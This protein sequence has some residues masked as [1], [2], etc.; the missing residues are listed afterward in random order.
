MQV[1]DIQ[2]VE[3]QTKKILKEAGRKNIPYLWQGKNRIT[4]DFSL[5]KPCK[6]QEWNE[7]FTVL[8]ENPPT[9]NSVS[10]VIVL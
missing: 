9:Q 1:Y 5:Q 4:S 8:K 2:V 7:V 10:S 3:Y 6:Q